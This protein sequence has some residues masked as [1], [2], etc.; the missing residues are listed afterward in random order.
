[1]GALAAAGR[2]D[3]FITATGGRDVVR[4]EHYELM[5]DGALLCNAGHFD[6]ELNLG[7]L[8]S[9][10]PER[11]AVRPHVE[12][13]ITPDGRRLNLLAQG[14]V[15]N[16][17]AAEG[18]PAAVMDVAFA[19]QALSAEYLVV[20][21]A[22]DALAARVHDVPRKIDDDVARLTLDAFGVEIDTLTPAQ[23]AYLTTWERGT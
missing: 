11:R 8:R 19:S 22:D 18:H 6:V 3:V 9:F 5:R 2:G 15:V 10:A 23:E 1:M 21:A 13:H 20:H 16:L 7:D 14:R 17:A 12:Q 4:R